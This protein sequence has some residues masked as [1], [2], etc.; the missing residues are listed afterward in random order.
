M[1]KMKSTKSKIFFFLPPRDEDSELDEGEPG[2]ILGES[3][4]SLRRVLLVGLGEGL[5][6]REGG[7]VKG[8][9]SYKG[10]IGEIDKL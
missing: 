2:I 3:N 5:L 1:F 7:E 6:E 10:E 4:R 9:L 8:G